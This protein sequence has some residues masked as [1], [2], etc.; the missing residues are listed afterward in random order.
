MERYAHLF[1][2]F[3]LLFSFLNY[4]LFV[5]K[6]M[7]SPFQLNHDQLNIMVN[8]SKSLSPYSMSEWNT[9]D[10]SPCLWERVT[11]SAGPST[12]VTGLSLSYLGLST[13][14]NVSDFISILCR[15]DTLQYLDFSL[16]YRTTIPDS[17][18][19]NC[20]GLSRLKSLNLSYN[21]LGGPVRN[22]SSFMSLET[23]D[24]FH[25]YLKGTVET[26]LSSLSKLKSL[27]LSSNLLMGTI[28][29]LVIDGRKVAA[30]EELVLSENQFNGTIPSEIFEYENLTVLD[31]ST[32]SLSGTIPE[33][34]GMLSNLNA[35]DLSSN[36][37]TGK[38]PA[39][40]SNIST[41][42]RFAAYGN[43]LTGNIPSIT[44]FL[45]SLDL[46]YNNLG[47]EIP[48]DLLASPNLEYVDLSHNRLGGA[49]PTNLSIG[50]LNLQLGG[51]LLSGIIPTSIGKLSK[52][53]YLDS[54][55]SLRMHCMASYQR[56]LV[57]F[58]NW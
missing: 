53:D 35:L 48:S 21:D 4:S 57:I 45:S 24:L 37:L 44:K 11:C 30:F 22:F 46:S 20:T 1:I 58:M 9:T 39:T 10:P 56:R 17:F 5:D 41:L 33:K 29:K 19:S 34:I 42:F 52:L 3:S 40:L 28:P 50:L 14:A 6:S 47:G 54:W 12:V 25:N 27:N 55:I 16:N 36:Q 2:S 32:N 26:Q 49:I 8:L 15:L 23:L 18:F 38:I 31:L 43:N 7:A 13:G 51:N